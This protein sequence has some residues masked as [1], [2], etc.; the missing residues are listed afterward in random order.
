MRV[1]MLGLLAVVLGGLLD[2]WLALGWPLRWVS[3]A[4]R[5]GADWAEVECLLTQMRKKV[6]RGN[7]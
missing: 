4:L 1:V 5:R 2:L 7:R 6:A 3:G